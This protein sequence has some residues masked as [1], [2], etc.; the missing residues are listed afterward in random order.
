MRGT[1]TS[2]STRTNQ[3][4]LA[5]LL[6]LFVAMPLIELAILIQIGTMI[7]IWPTIGIVL[8]TGTAGALLARSQ[9]TQVLRKIRTEMSVGRVP[10]GSLIDGLMVLIGGIVLLT[11][12][13]LTDLL[14]LAL[15]LPVTR[16]RLKGAIRKRMQAMVDSGEV[17]VVTLVR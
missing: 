6:L 4:M 11:P 14:G 13:V 1:T 17:N 8:L 9:G 7:G 15:L 12:G 3:T 10:T 16:S 5:R 2:R